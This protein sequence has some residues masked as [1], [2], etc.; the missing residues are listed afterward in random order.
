MNK[1]DKNKHMKYFTILVLLILST[2]I[3]AQTSDKFADLIEVINN[4]KIKAVKI[5]SKSDNQTIDQ[6]KKMISSVG[7]TYSHII[8]FDGYKYFPVVIF[9]SNIFFRNEKEIKL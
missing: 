6:L 8:P 5:I 2:N 1:R 9:E 4:G 3:Q 7:K